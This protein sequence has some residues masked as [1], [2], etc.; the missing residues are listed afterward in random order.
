MNEHY[1]DPCVYC[2]TPHDEV[3]VGNCPG[4]M[5]GTDVTEARRLSDENIRLLFRELHELG[6]WRKAKPQQIRRAVEVT[7]RLLQCGYSADEI[8]AELR[9]LDA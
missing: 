7:Q 6:D 4:R 5:M 8:K 9:R 2:G 3:A 1:G